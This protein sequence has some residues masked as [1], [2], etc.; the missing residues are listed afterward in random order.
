MNLEYLDDFTKSELYFQI[1]NV[2]YI[3][4]KILRAQS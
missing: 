1:I 3:R 2:R 4:N